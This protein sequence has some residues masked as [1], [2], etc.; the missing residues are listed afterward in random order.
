MNSRLNREFVLGEIEGEFDFLGDGDIEEAVRL[1]DTGTSRGRVVD[2]LASWN[3]Q[4][5]EEAAGYGEAARE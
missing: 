5:A 4:Q 2:L 1:L 3:A